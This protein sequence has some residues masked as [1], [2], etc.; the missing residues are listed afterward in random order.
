[1]WTK[2]TIEDLLFGTPDE[3]LFREADRVRQEVCGDEVHLRGIL[4]FSNHCWKNCLYCGLRRDNRSLQR[5]RMLP[6]EIVALA[7]KAVGEGMRTIVLQSGEDPWY[8][9]DRVTAIL[10]GIKKKAGCALTLSLGERGERELRE[11]KEA[12]ADRYLLKHETA[13]PRLFNSLCPETTLEKRLGCLR[14]MKSLGYQAGS[15]IL[16]GLPGQRPEDYVEDLLLLRSLDV[17][18]A[19]IGPFIP[20]PETPLGHERGGDARDVLRLIAVARIVLRE[21]HIPA[22]TALGTVEREGREKGLRV[23]AN[24]VMANLTPLRYRRQYEIYPNRICA[25]ESAERCP[26]C[27][28][29]RITN[30]GRKVSQDFG[31]SLKGERHAA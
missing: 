5:Y 29:Q 27:L 18:M 17:D 15:G 31:H 1:M 13:N 14:L 28:K 21:V 4:E 8:T 30:L 20:H 12:G 25:E 9:K 10:R 16:A 6:D 23:G 3:L 11:W 19:G 22:T 24:V 7:A 26:E 2:A